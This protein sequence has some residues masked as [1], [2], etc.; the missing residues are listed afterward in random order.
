MS[1]QVHYGCL[2][3]GKLVDNNDNNL[4]EGLYNY[5]AWPTVKFMNFGRKSLQFEFIDKPSQVRLDFSK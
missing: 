2:F 3:I 5:V 1:K 4:S